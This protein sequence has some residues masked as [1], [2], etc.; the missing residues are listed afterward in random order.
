[1]VQLGMSEELQFLWKLLKNEHSG[2][3][4]M[5]EI[6]AYLCKSRPDVFDLRKPGDCW[7][8]CI[9]VPGPLDKVL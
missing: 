3:A 9:G 4:N 8:W 2:Y 5:Y 1:M 6:A 7:V